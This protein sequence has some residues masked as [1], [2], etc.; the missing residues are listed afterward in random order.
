MYA[1]SW[2]AYGPNETRSESYGEPEWQDACSAAG[3]AADGQYPDRAGA[4]AAKDA[5]EA[6][7]PDEGC[8]ISVR[9]VQ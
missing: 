4:E 1:L 9:I 7:L 3:I 2:K 5:V 6:K 8:M